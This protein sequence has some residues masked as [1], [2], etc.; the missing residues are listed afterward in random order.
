MRTRILITLSGR[1]DKLQK[2]TFGSDMWHYPFI[3]IAQ[4]INVTLPQSTRRI[5]L[6]KTTTHKQQQQLPKCNIEKELISLSFVMDSP[7]IASISQ[8]NGDLHCVCVCVCVSVC[9]CVCVRWWL[10][11]CPAQFFVC[12]LNIYVALMIKWVCIVHTHTHTH[13][14]LMKTSHTV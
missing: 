6:K 13:T 8:Y 5:D 1:I 9:V 11:I 7:N 4:L 14:L 2:I 12:M 3:R 10:Y